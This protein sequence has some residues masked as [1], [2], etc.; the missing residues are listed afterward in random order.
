[1]PWSLNVGVRYI[2]TDVTAEGQNSSKVDGDGWGFNIGALFSLS[3]ATRLGVHYRSSVK[4]ELDGDTTF[5]GT[6]PQLA[7]GPVKLEVDTPHT[8]SG[9]QV[10]TCPLD[11]ILAVSSDMS[12][13]LER[14]VQSSSF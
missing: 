13:L 7:N 3:P 11:C 10:P 5:T 14:G 1:M 12:P 9:G 6:P 2:H 4:L 8:N